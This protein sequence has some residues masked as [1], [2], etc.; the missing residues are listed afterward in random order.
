MATLHSSPTFEAARAY[1][2]AMLV[3]RDLEC[4]RLQ[5]L[6]DA[7]RAGDGGAVLLRGVPGA[8]KSALLEFAA[9]RAEDPDRAAG[10]G[11]TG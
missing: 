7:T 8:G 3:G 10:G 2:R 9:G 5:S 4:R 1:A 11:H 6:I